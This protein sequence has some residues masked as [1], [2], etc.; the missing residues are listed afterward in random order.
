MADEKQT[1][2]VAGLPADER[3]DRGACMGSGNCVYWAPEVFGLDD[4]GVAIVLGDAA[5]HE[6]QVRQAAKNCPTRAI[7]LDTFFR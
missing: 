3:I 6:E 2:T 7:Q 4:D 1:G 5:G